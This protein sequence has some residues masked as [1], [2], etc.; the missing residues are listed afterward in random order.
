MKIINL[1]AT[2][3]YLARDKSIIFVPW[4]Y[5]VLDSKINFVKSS[6]TQK[7]VAY[8]KSATKPFFNK[9]GAVGPR[10]LKLGIQIGNQIWTLVLRLIRAWHTSKVLPRPFSITLEPLVLES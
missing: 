8:F 5:Y 9:S 7:G 2:N 3:L 1:H 10:K 6:A 4:R